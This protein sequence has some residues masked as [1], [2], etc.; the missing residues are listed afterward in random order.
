[1][2]PM[3]ST[4]NFIFINLACISFCFAQS[5]SSSPVENA[6]SLFNASIQTQSRLYNGAFYPGY[7][8]NVDGSAN[9]QDL[10]TFVNGSVV[11]DGFRFNNVP[12]MYDIYQD[13]LISLLNGYSK[14]SLISNRVAEFY[15]NDHHFKYINVIDSTKSVIKS[16]FYDLIY[17]GIAK[18]YVKKIK[19]MQYS[20]DKKIV[21]YY[22]IPKTYYYIERDQK[23]SVISGEKSFLSY[24]NDKK[25]ELKKLLREK[26]IKFRKQPENAMILIVSYYENL[27]N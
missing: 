4:L 27:T 20:L 7:A 12:L 25:P 5:I 17:D 22:F 24:F 16:G 15:L 3:K 23:Y 8:F 19:N 10:N 1:M 13:K 21:H 14:F 11:Y 9:F 18:I 26:K 2:S 6:E